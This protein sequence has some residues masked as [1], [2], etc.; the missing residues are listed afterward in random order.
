MFNLIRN[1]DVSIRAESGRNRKG[2]TRTVAIAD[3]NG[4]FEHRFPAESRV[5]KALEVMT[6]DQLS[7]RL[8]GGQFFFM[9]ERLVDFRDS[10]YHGFVHSDEAIGQLMD[11]LGTTDTTIFGR[12]ARLLKG[13]THAGHLLLGKVWSE[14][15]IQVP[16]YQTG[17]EFNSRLIFVWNPFTRTIN[18]LFQLVRLIC[19]NGMTG[20]TS[21]LNTKVPVINRWEEHLEIANRQIQ[22][23]VEGIAKLRFAQ[24]G[25][26]RASVAEVDQLFGHALQRSKAAIENGLVSEADRLRNISTIVNPRIHLADVYRAEVFKDKRLGAQLPSHLTAFDAYNIATEIRTHTSESDTS[27]SLALDRFANG[28]LFDREDLSGQIGSFAEP[29]TSSFSDPDQAFFGTVH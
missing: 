29:P 18:T 8:S 17:G 10:Q 11:H 27:S 21:F 16:G 2:A 4:R 23:K 13:N 26:E 20:L 12:G 19:T 6:P 24:M 1:A 9:D 22:N 25:T 15:G 3:I 5:S 14:H 28:I 7:Q